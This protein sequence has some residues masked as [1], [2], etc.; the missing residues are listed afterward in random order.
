M[1]SDNYILLSI[2]RQPQLYN[3]LNIDSIA[4]PIRSSAFS[5]KFLLNASSLRCRIVPQTGSIRCS[6]FMKS[7]R[8]KTRTICLPCPRAVSRLSRRSLVTSKR[9]SRDPPTNQ[10]KSGNT[11]N[12]DKHCRPIRALAYRCS[13]CLYRPVNRVYQRNFA[14]PRRH[15]G[16]CHQNRRKERHR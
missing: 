6:R 16:V 3:G 14:Y 11:G 1:R 15:K 5:R 12:S 10:S 13:S 4:F 9:P 8:E 7:I 2:L